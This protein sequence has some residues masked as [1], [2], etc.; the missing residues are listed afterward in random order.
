MA[1]GT[2]NG[3]RL[4]SVVTWTR[5]A[6]A[7]PMRSPVASTSPDTT[8]DSNPESHNVCSP[9]SATAS[10]WISIVP[11]HGARSCSGSAPNSSTPSPTVAGGSKELSRV[12]VSRACR[13]GT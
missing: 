12:R 8:P 1:E 7:A 9:R 13:N 10:S 3:G 11:G 6:F 2:K 4:S 5:T